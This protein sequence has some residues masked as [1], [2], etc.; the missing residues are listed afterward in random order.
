M[1]R[2]LDL[3][4]QGIG[5]TA[6]NPMVGAVLVNGGLIIGEGYHKACGGSHAE[7]EC[8]NSVAQANIDLIHNSTL[9][10]SLEP[11]SHFGKTPPCA[12]LIIKNR[13]PSVVIGCEDSFE[14]VNGSGI[15]KL[16]AAGIQVET[17]ILKMEC[18]ELNKRF[19]T[20]H[21]KKRPYIILKW[22]QSKNG[23]IGG[24]SGKTIKI[25]NAFTDRLVH[26]WRSEESG[27]LAGT[28]T[29]LNDDPALTVRHWTGKNPVRIIF[30]RDLKIPPAAKV[31]D[32]KAKTLI[33]NRN[34]KETIGN[35][36]FYKTDGQNNIAEYA[37]SVIA[38]DQINS[39]M[40]E[41]GSITLQSF[42]NAGLWDE[43]RVLTNN[44]LFIN[45][46]ISAPRL[47]NEALIGTQNIFSD[48]ISIY[49]NCENEFL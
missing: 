9:Y 14:K 8:L 37:V 16:R 34:K 13:I 12:D 7:V 35:N 44:D 1:K 39:I 41:G 19:F 21:E 23:K 27:I 25:T 26:K 22:A 28:E 40:I 30:D 20:F 47:I 33:L 42:I 6:P 17:N 24:K 45:S 3:A 2:C 18:R 36:I 38:I 48:S 11:C 31:F 4:A 5:N 46:G 43:A 29:V 32:G 15:E 10:V 49:K